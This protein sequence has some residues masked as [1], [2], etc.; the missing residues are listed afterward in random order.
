MNRFATV[1]VM[2]VFVTMAGGCS[3][4]S[5]RGASSLRKLEAGVVDALEEGSL[6][7]GQRFFLDGARFESLCEERFRTRNKRDFRRK[8]A[9]S[10]RRFA[11]H[12]E[13]CGQRL[14]GDVEVLRRDG[15]YKRRQM[16]GCAESVWEYADLDLTVRSNGRTHRVS[17]EGILGIEGRY[18]L[19]ERVRCR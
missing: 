16:D 4:G 18:Y 13:A 9:N 7:A 10:M 15:G 2:L 8:L 6:Q 17:I 14:G 1:P 19:V 5:Q 11:R 12:F 3:E